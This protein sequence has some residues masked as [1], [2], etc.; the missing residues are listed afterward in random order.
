LATIT[1]EIADNGGDKD[2]GISD[3]WIADNIAC[4][5]RSSEYHRVWQVSFSNYFEELDQLPSLSPRHGLLQST[6]QSIFLCD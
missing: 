6:L 5:T 2:L 3:E 4:Q 1:S